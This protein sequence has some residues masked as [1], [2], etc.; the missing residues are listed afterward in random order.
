LRLRR[1]PQISNLKP[2]KS[3]EIKI[4]I[5]KIVIVKKT[6]GK[7]KKGGSKT[8]QAIDISAE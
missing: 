4:A 1:K 7:N 2:A 5:A 3:A 8:W 6:V